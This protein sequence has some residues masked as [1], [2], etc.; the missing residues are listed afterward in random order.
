MVATDNAVMVVEDSIY[1]AQ[2]VPIIFAQ[3]T[4]TSGKIISMK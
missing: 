1:H 4:T 2:N 3:H